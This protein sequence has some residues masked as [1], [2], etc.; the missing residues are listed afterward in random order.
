MLKRSDAEYLLVTQQD[1]DITISICAPY[2]KSRR[3]K[4]QTYAGLSTK[5][6]NFVANRGD[7]ITTSA[8]AGATTTL[9]VQ[10][11]ETR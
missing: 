8:F 3:M 10:L 6:A 4:D 2:D 11:D 7:S 9:Q 1:V 5:M